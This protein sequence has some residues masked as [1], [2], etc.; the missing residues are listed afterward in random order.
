LT[1][2]RAEKALSMPVMLATK[3]VSMLEGTIFVSIA[4]VQA[5]SS[6]FS[7]KTAKH[8]FAT[9]FLETDAL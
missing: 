5:I 9:Y 2:F 3:N 7:C 1:K 6:S 8:L 4:K